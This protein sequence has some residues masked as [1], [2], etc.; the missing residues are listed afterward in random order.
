[1]SVSTVTKQ[2]IESGQVALHRYGMGI[3]FAANVLGAGSVYI[4]SQ[5]GANVGFAL[6]WVLPLAFGVDFV[7]HEMGGRLASRGEPLMGHARD[8]MGPRLAPIFGVSM[9]LVMQLWGVANYAVAGAAFAWFTGVPVVAGILTV[10]GAAFV[11]IGVQKYQ[12][13]ELW[14]TGLLLSL[15]AVYVA[16]TLGLSPPMGDISMGFIPSNFN[17]PALIIAMIGTTVYY[18]N[19]FIQSSM[20]PTKEWTD[21][22]RYRRDNLAGI[23]MSVVVSAA[24][25]IVAGMT[26]TDAGQ[27]SLTDPAIPIVAG[28]GQWAL[29]AFVFAVF[30][31]SFTSATGTLF[32]SGF[33]VPQSFGVDTV[34]GDR[35]FRLTMMSLI[36]M[37]AV[38]AS[39]ALTYTNMTPVEMAI[40]MPALNGA[41]FLPLTVLFLLYG[42]WEHLSIKMRVAG[43]TAGMVMFAGSIL[44]AQGLYDTIVTAF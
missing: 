13:V 26:L 3:L 29:P 15:S 35:G 16:F 44:T 18:P 5:T 33:A 32:G 40:I 37:S 22:S 11:L 10:A 39:L 25:L 27:L 9:A 36:A 8:L 19:F 7:L 28:A 43:V 2:V 23:T 21:I 38:G 1:M 41:I 42:T 31:A 30:A 20:R 12:R 17:E 34:F 4:L 24:I 14:V 6:L